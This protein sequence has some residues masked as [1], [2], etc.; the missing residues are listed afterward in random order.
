MSGDIITLS[1]SARWVWQQSK[2]KV[3]TS[4]AIST[5][6]S[7]YTFSDF[8]IT[9]LTYT[10]TNNDDYYWY[11]SSNNSIS[12][13]KSNAYMSFHL[14]NGIVDKFTGNGSKPSYDIPSFS[15]SCGYE[16]EC[17]VK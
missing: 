6:Q 12:V 13:T 1:G 3:F 11:I 14:S 15:C 5:N 10:S 17:I 9:K 7:G 8:R 16:I 2:D 4:G